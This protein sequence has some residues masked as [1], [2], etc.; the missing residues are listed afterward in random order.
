MKSGSQVKCLFQTKLYSNLE[1]VLCYSKWMRKWN[2]QRFV[3]SA[4]GKVQ[5]AL[6]QCI[7]RRQKLSYCWIASLLHM[8]M[9]PKGCTNHR[10]Q[11]SAVTPSGP[12]RERPDTCH[13]WER[14]EI[15][16]A[17]V[18][19]SSS[20]F[21]NSPACT[22]A[23]PPSA[24]SPACS[25]KQHHVPKTTSTISLQ[26]YY[27]H[28][29]SDGRNTC[30]QAFAFRICTKNGKQYFHHVKIVEIAIRFLYLHCL[31]LCTDVCLCHRCCP[32]Q[33][34]Q[35]KWPVS[36]LWR[37][38]QVQWSGGRMLKRLNRGWLD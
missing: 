36:S 22:T 10:P 33:P 29:C 31:N 19:I 4:P 32:W 20:C 28:C 24:A 27:C 38:C 7:K 26:A 5:T 8:L 18:L 6:I 3:S 34:L 9:K 14:W 11:I 23:G 25:A 12:N 17:A 13:T 37:S 30:D 16:R 1:V 15:Q 35:R 2:S 21:T